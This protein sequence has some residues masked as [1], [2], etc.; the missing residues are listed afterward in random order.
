[1]DMQKKQTTTKY[2]AWG[3]TTTTRLEESQCEKIGKSYKGKTQKTYRPEIS[4]D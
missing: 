2:S 1:M 3:N 4:S